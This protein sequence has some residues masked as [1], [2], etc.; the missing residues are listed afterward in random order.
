RRSARVLGLL[1]MLAAAPAQA[2]DWPARMVTIV[3]P[4]APGGFTD[5]L[6]RLAAKH[7]SDKFHQPFMIENRLGAGGAIGAAYVANA[8]PDGYTLMFGSAMQLGVSPLIQKVGYE[9]DAF[10]PVAVFGTIPFLLG[11]KASLPART[12]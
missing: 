12:V 7:L 1:A 10:A 9:A 6:A 5:T 8:A 11:I 2:A 4:Y 3:V